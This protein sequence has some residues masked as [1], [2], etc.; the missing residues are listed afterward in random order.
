MAATTPFFRKKEPAPSV[1]LNDLSSATLTPTFL[2]IAFDTICLATTPGGV[3]Y[4]YKP[5]IKE[6]IRY[7]VKPL[8]LSIEFVPGE[9]DLCMTFNYLRWR[10][11]LQPPESWIL[12]TKKANT[13]P[14]YEDT[15]VFK[16]AIIEYI[17]EKLEKLMQKPYE[18]ALADINEGLNTLLPGINEKSFA[19]LKNISQRVF[20]NYIRYHQ[21]YS[22]GGV[23]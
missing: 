17:D 12:E 18:E 4:D 19:F 6:I 22:Y 23:I 3:R 9:I 1:E 8:S 5:T 11:K 15:P 20:D 7:N 16:F 2:Q 21:D 14:N 10:S 13:F